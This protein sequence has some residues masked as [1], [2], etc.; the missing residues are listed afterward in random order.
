MLEHGRGRPPFSPGSRGVVDGSKALKERNA[1]VRRG[2]RVVSL[3]GESYNPPKQP[4]KS[5]FG[6]PV[7]RP[8][9][10]RTL[11]RLSVGRSLKLHRGLAATIAL[12]GLMAAG[13]YLCVNALPGESHAIASMPAEVLTFEGVRNASLLFFFGLF[14]ALAA[15]VVASRLD[16][17]IYVASDVRCAVGFDPLAALPDFR[18]VSPGVAEDRLQRLAA[19][20]E[21]AHLR[22]DLHSCLF[23]GAGY[24][25][26]VSVVA[27][28]V[29]ALLTSMG[30]STVLLEASGAAPLAGCS[31]VLVLQSARQAPNPRKGLILTDAAPLA[32]SA[33]T[34][35]LS[36]FVDSVIVVVESGATT[37]KQLQE[38]A[39]QLR[40][41]NATSVSVV[42]NKVSLSKADADF[43]NSIA[44]VDR[45]LSGHNRPAVICKQNAASK[46]MGEEQRPETPPKRKSGGSEQQLDQPPLASR[47]NSPTQATALS[48]ESARAA[49]LPPEIAAEVASLIASLSDRNELADRRQKPPASALPPL[50]PICGPRPL[51]QPKADQASK[52]QSV[53]WADSWKRFTSSEPVADCGQAN[54]E[55]KK[56]AAVMAGAASPLEERGA[57]L[58]SSARVASLRSLMLSLGDKM[59]VASKTD[60]IQ[61]AFAV[62]A[63]REPAGGKM[64]LPTLDAGGQEM[65]DDRFHRERFYGSETLPSHYGQ[66]KKDS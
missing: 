25:V 20:I 5:A 39:E 10:W 57:Q 47:S 6:Q 16:E 9:G 7:T 61:S 11:L 19:A 62:A 51:S 53:V 36:R 35:R 48:G 58:D 23:T 15:A 38:T 12:L 37:S 65:E 13:A 42:L 32:L 18:Q 41:L 21:Y 22:S 29:R 46:P 63:F 17:K 31:A 26:G 14:L 45:Y 49:N 43:R 3:M 50:P 34:E 64:Q 55:E 1:N 30:Y 52:P 44:A 40:R 60:P 28:R 33:E 56:Q 8:A 24:G 54:A 4:Q 2:R 27:G 66:Y 59:R